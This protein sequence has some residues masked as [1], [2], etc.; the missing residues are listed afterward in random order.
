MTAAELD[1]IP[2]IKDL[3]FRCET[4]TDLL[5]LPEPEWIVE[6]LIPEGAFVLIYGPSG[7]GKSFLALDLA[8][9]VALKRD[10]WFGHDIDQRARVLYVAAEGGGGILKRVR[11]FNQYHGIVDDDCPITMI[12]HSVDLLDRTTAEDLVTCWAGLGNPELL[13][14]DTWSRCLPGGN[15]SATE[16]TT[17]AIATL[18]TFR[19]ETGCPVVVVHHSPLADNQRPRGS[20]ALI[21]AADVALAVDRAG[22]QRVA[23]LMKNRD[24]ETDIKLAFTLK[25][26]VVGQDKKGREI[27]SCVVE[28]A[29]IIA[30]P[31]SDHLSPNLQTM[32]TVLSES[33]PSGLTA[34]EWNEKARAVG[35]DPK[36]AAT[37][38][39]WKKAL[40]G[41]RRVHETQGRWFVKTL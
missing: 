12:R 32:F 35:L 19:H 11:A 7:C 30:D 16:D 8:F 22:E 40:E 34:E 28:P 29:E 20:T 23:K 15:E 2:A 3:P 1:A 27:T 5:A 31:H 17:A 25:S 18:D 41:K 38:W 6:G 13:F 4:M 37:F 14:I 26:L 10:R 39:D 9:H 36:R 33:M 24:G 21:A